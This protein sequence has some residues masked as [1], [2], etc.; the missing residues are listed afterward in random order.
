MR[1]TYKP[2]TYRSATKSP[3][4]KIPVGL[5]I[6]AS[7]VYF[8]LIGFSSVVLTVVVCVWSKVTS[9][10]VPPISM[11][12][13]P[14]SFMVMLELLTRPLVLSNRMLPLDSLLFKSAFMILNGR[15]PP[16]FG[17]GGWYLSDVFTFVF[18]SL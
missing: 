3:R 1:E 14:V 12:R 7:S 18:C 8:L 13:V 10:A 16:A 4:E 2:E 6:L 9:L 11:V 17:P 15:F 5:R